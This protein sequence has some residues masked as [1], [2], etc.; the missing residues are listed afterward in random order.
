M[1]E[2]SDRIPFLLSISLRSSCCIR[3][4]MIRHKC[5]YSQLINMIFSGIILELSYSSCTDNL[6]SGTQMHAQFCT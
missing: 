2:R 4:L 1:P 5:S 3:L 6:E